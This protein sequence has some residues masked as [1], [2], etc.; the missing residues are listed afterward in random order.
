MARRVRIHSKDGAKQRVGALEEGRCRF[1]ALIMRRNGA[2]V[3]ISSEEGQNEMNQGTGGESAPQTEG[4]ERK[5]TYGKDA[6]KAFVKSSTLLHL[7]SAMGQLS[8]LSLSDLERVRQIAVTLDETVTAT[9]KAE[10]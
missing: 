8:A 7:S 3:G 1:G 6:R 4:A 10:L 2:R 9:A 5:R